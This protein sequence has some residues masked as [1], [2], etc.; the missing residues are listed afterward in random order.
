MKVN[1]LQQEI[2]PL[3]FAGSFGC[4]LN[5][6]KHSLSLCFH[7]LTDT[8]KSYATDSSCLVNRAHF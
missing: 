8:S 7:L 3:T 6:A 4:K 5:S 1:K 2:N